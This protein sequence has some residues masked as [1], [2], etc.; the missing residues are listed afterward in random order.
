MRASQNH[1]KSHRSLQL[2]PLEDRRLL[3]SDLRITEFMASNGATLDDGDGNHGG[4]RLGQALEVLGEP[5]IA[6]QP[7][8]AALD[9]PALGQEHEALG[10]AAPDDREAQPGSG[11]DA[12][13][14]VALV[15]GIRE[16]A[17]EPGKPGLDPVADQA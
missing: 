12:G 13:G 17:G 8:E 1:L 9:H 15:A 11:G 4:G 7:G 14:D 5:A 10:V 2:E 16:Q 3:A 6:A